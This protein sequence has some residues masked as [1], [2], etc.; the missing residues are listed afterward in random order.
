MSLVIS[1]PLSAQQFINGSFEGAQSSCRLGLSNS[2][3]M[4]HVENTISFGTLRAGNDLITDNCGLG[5]PVDGDYFVSLSMVGTVFNPRD[6]TIIGLE[7]TQPIIAGNSYTISFYLKS[8]NRFGERNFVQ[9]GLGN[10]LFDFGP[11]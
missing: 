6:R 2:G 9:F 11:V 3:F 4:S 5:S 8:S 1:L 7:L 10:G